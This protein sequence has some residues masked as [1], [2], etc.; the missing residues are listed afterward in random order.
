MHLEDQP[1]VDSGRI[2]LKHLLTLRKGEPAYDN[3][4]GN[5]SPAVTDI[6]KIKGIHENASDC[7]FYERS[8]KRCRIYDHRPVEC[9]ALK[10]WDTRQIEGIYNCRRL[11]RR[12]LLS[13][14]KGLWELVEDH[15]Q[16]CDYSYIAE[17]VAKIK[18]K[19]KVQEATDALLELIRYDKHLRDVTFKRTNL[20]FGMLS[21]LFGRPLSFTIKLFRIQM[22]KTEQGITF[23]PIGPTDAKICHVSS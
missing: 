8:Q 19:C 4:I 13:K 16:R 14:V 21:F 20:E 5:I 7:V 22:T 6:L 17:L 10:C 15:Q 18:Q 3:V 23:E 9:Q 11:T 2:P 12:H 1:L